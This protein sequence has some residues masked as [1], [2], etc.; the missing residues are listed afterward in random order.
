MN[1]INSI[2]GI[3]LE[4][5]GAK[6]IIGEPYEKGADPHGL[7]IKVSDE[8]KKH[9]IMGYT[10][11]VNTLKLIFKYQTLRSSSL[12]N[13]NLNDPMEK[14]RVGVNEYA[15]GRFITC[16]CHMDHESVPF[17][18]YYGKNIRENKVLMQFKNF[19]NSFE[20]SIY[21]DYVLVKDNKKVLCNSKEYGK[22]IN[23]QHID[24]SISVE[25][26]LRG[27]IESVSMFD[28]EY[29]PCTS[30]V[31]KR[32]Y[33]GNANIDF[34]QIIDRKKAVISVKAYDSTVLGK[35]KSDPWDYEKETRILCSVG[36]RFLGWDYIDLRLK[37]EIFRNLR[38]TL[39]PWDNGKLRSQVQ[40][41]IED[42]EL[43]QEIKDSIV[44]ADSLLKGK[45]NFP[46]EYVDEKKCKSSIICNKLSRNRGWGPKSR[47][48]WRR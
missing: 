26:D 43:S 45:L 36:A 25:Y 9:Q 41:A 30:E 17:W 29:V 27:C 34:G 28:V 39:S 16:F 19:A 21:T 33:S 20:N 35:K 6:F 22:K 31:F 5:T 24:E 12:T 3:E 7:N 23:Q 40:K 1:L 38:I 14:E 2:S 42:S 13:A 32:D 10:T 37:Q 18:M 46:E 8:S 44:I 11:D 15:A 4:P 48:G 47:K